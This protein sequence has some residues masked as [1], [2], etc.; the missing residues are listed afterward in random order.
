MFKTTKLRH[1]N[2]MAK[3]VYTV[4]R[5]YPQETYTHNHFTAIIQVNLS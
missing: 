2:K 3:Q 4:L 5:K 1:T